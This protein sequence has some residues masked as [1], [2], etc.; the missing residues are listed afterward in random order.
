VE[1]VA[2]YGKPASKTEVISVGTVI[3]TRKA[4]GQDHRIE[5]EKIGAG[6]GI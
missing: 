2:S 6:D 1:T 3:E 4:P 5:V